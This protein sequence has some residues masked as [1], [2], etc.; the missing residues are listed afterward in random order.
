[1][2]D[3]SSLVD[4][5]NVAGEIF[6]VA[7]Q[8]GLT[9]SSSAFRAQVFQLMKKEALPVPDCTTLCIPKSLPVDTSQRL[10]CREH[11]VVG[12]DSTGLKVYGEG[13]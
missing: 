2:K 11:P 12:T 5:K 10:Q 8:S 1:V 7:S 13:K 9:A 4:R 6:G 3:W